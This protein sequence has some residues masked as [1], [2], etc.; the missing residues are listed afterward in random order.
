MIYSCNKFT[1]PAVRQ[2]LIQKAFPNGRLHRSGQVTAT[3]DDEVFIM[4]IA[5]PSDSDEDAEV[6]VVEVGKVCMGVL[7]DDDHD[8]PALPCSSAT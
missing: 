6:V 8:T 5:V 2:S 7:V 4:A 3:H 1:D